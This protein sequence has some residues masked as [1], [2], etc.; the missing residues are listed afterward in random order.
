MQIGCHATQAI[1]NHPFIH[2][3]AT[4][5]PGSTRT[6]KPTLFLQQTVDQAIFHSGWVARLLRI[7]D[8]FRF[9]LTNPV[10]GHMVAATATVFWLFQFVR[11]TKVSMRAK[12]DLE[13]CESFLERMAL[14]WPHIAQ[15]V[16]VFP[17][18]VE[19][20]AVLFRRAKH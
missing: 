15:K 18:L 4:R 3:V 13:K 8:D 7:M 17:G 16:G 12:E 11:D 5:P 19:T 20:P 1:L 14:Q 2:L 10:I 6:L 9:E